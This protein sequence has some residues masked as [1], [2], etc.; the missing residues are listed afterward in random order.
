M[1]WSLYCQRQI[2]VIGDCAALPIF[3]AASV[4]N[5]RMIG[6][7][8]YE[9]GN[10]RSVQKGFEQVGHDAAIISD[11]TGIADVTHLVLPGVGAFADGMEHLQRLGFVEPILE[12]VAAN[13]LMLG[14]CLGMQ[15]LFESSTEDAPSDD[16]PVKGLGIFPGQVVQFDV[17]RG[18]EHTGKRIK[19]PHMGWNALEWEV[20]VP[21]EISAESD[22]CQASPPALF[23]GLKSGAFVYFVHGYYA[24][25]G[26]VVDGKSAVTVGT[27]QYPAGEPFCSVVNVGQVWAT[28]F[29]PEKSQ[30]VG[31]QMLKNFASM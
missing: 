9:M 28:Q 15:L 30:H 2:V 5:V 8:D 14:I 18:I 7:I 11:P 10:L 17:N 12:H 23:N 25:P 22:K 13:K 6:I 31:L 26:D 20:K 29:H 16:D 21:K 27:A 3:K 19:V 4:Y 24:Q 1:G